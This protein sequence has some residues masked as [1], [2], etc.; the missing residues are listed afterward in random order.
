MSWEQIQEGPAFGFTVVALIVVFGP[1]FAERVRLPGLLGLLVGGALIGPNMLDVLPSFDSL[2][3]LGTIGVLYLIFL[4]GLQLDI[5]SFRRHRKIS[6]GFGL[7]TAF[8]PLVLGTIA[9]LLLGIDATAA[10]LIGSFWASFTLITYPTVSKYGLTKQRSVAAI[11]GASSITDTISLIILALI[12]GAETGDSSGFGLVLSIALGLVA[13][14]LWCLVVVPWFARSVFTGLGQERT[15]RYMIVLIALTSSAVVA[16]VVGIEA[17]IGAFFAGVGMN[18]LVPNASPLMTVTDFFG[19]AF[20]IPMFLVSVGLLFDSEVMFVGDTLRLAAGFAIALVLGKGIAAWLSGRIFDLTFPEVGLMF[21]MSI[22]QAAATLAATIIGLEAGLYGDDI[23]NAVM[24][25]VA[26]SLVITSV[27]TSRFA[28]QISPPVGERRRVGEAVLLPTANTDTETLAAVVHLA[29]RLTEPVGGVVQPLV[30]ATS[31][32]PEAIERARNEQARAD[33]VL[34][35]S[36]QDVETDL[37]VD[38]S[39]ASGLNRNAIQAESSLLLLA[40][41]GPK[42]ARGYLLGASYSEIVAAT[43]VPTMIAAL[44]PDGDLTE[45]RLALVVRDEDLGPGNVPSLRIAADVASTLAQRGRPL[46]VGP[47]GSEDLAAVD[48][49]LPEA[50]EYPGGPD[51]LI[52]WVRHATEPGDTIVL[53]FL[54]IELKSAAIE[55]YDSGRSVLAVTPNPESRSA[56]NGSTMT[57]P[58]GGTLTPS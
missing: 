40:W 43:S 48:V 14:A 25:V 37:R 1:L 49:D 47:V 36:G 50:V 32:T 29:G 22:A 23:V 21:S 5:D 11:V 9:A 10:V 35:R 45:T 41:P 56:L 16:E 46:I 13:L 34:R 17:L 58:V 7:L 39:I 44:H 18:R 6:F 12:I 2:D 8:I 20:F 33:S 54:G 51:D 38:R 55:I 27:G 57:L 15:L 26:V 31:T 28:S 42:D 3:A 52:E 24:V 4:A 19:N 53:P 30:V